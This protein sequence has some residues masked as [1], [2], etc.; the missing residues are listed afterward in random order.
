MTVVNLQHVLTLDLGHTH[1]PVRK[2][3]PEMEK[4]V[5]VRK[6]ITV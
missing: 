1:V 6:T 4:F 3:T 5:K 2:V